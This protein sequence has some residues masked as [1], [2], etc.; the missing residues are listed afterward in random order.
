M[1]DIRPFKGIR[2]NPDKV[3]DMGRVITPPYDVI[4]QQE[5]DRL[6]KQDLYNIVRLEYG[7]TRTGD[8]D[9]DNRYTRAADTLERWLA[10]DVLC[11]E[12]SAG[13]YLYEQ[14]FIYNGRGMSR[15]GIIAA[16]RLELYERRIV[17]PHELTMKGPK[18]DRLA[19]LNATRTNISPIFTLFPDPEDIVDR[20]FESVTPGEMLFEARENSGQI[21]R[22]WIVTEKGVLDDISKYFQDCQLL[23]ADGHHRYETALQYAGSGSRSKNDGAC[24]VLSTIISMKDPGLLALP[25]HRLLRGLSEKEENDLWAGLDE[26]FV[27]LEAGGLAKLDLGKFQLEL[28]KTAAE[29]SGF[30]LFHSGKAYL[31]QP[32]FTPGRGD[33]AVSLLHEQLLDRTDNERSDFPDQTET[34]QISFEHDPSKCLKE[35]RDSNAGWAFILGPVPVEKIFERSKMGLVMPRKSTYFYPKLPGGLVLYHMDLS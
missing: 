34:P 9:L 27:L 33:L 28:A 32:K 12:R 6:H 26:N 18:K 3:K 24:Y 7:L 25:T 29:K 35:V 1:A 14:D 4:D 16:L 15:R 10:D 23:I 2:F 5:Q 19:L 11:P 22:L 17:L 30:G 21:H 8:N 20:L 31:I 13:F